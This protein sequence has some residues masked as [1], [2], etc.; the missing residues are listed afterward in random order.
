ML[1]WRR[2]LVS[3]RVFPNMAHVWETLA[4]ELPHCKIKFYD[5]E[6][7][8]DYLRKAGVIALG[9]RLTLTVDRKLFS[10]AKAGCKLANFILAHELGHVAL[11]HHRNG[12]VTKNFQ[13]FS[14]ANGMSNI[15]PTSEELETNY[16]A[17]FFQCGMELLN[18][19]AEHL[20][21]AHRAGTDVHYV[22][23][24][25]DRTRLDIFKNELNRQSN[26]FKRV[27]L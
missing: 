23:K 20:Q 15:P 4:A 25:L 10:N 24:A 17:V 27:I 3:D 22:K 26:R 13:L 11:D 7:V 18:P 21:L 2:E 14:S 19:Y 9:E 16:A 12:K 1:W 8:E 6:V 5:S